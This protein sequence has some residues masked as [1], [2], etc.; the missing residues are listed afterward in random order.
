MAALAQPCHHTVSKTSSVCKDVSEHLL[1]K[2]TAFGS[3]GNGP[4]DPLCSSHSTAD[5]IQPFCTCVRAAAEAQ[6][7][8]PLLHV[9][10]AVAN[11]SALHS[12]HV[13]SQR[14]QPAAG[15]SRAGAAD[16]GARWTAKASS[17]Q[18]GNPHELVRAVVFP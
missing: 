15:L 18:T 8:M 1:I 17:D 9:G 10:R 6:P 13:A 4:Q 3:V 16:A 14:A 5:Q 2:F 11:A 7:A 12:R